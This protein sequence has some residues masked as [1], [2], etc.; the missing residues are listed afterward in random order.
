MNKILRAKI[1]FYKIIKSSLNYQPT[2]D[3]SN[4]ILYL[5]YEYELPHDFIKSRLQF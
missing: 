3:R 2:E 5:N 4:S 1:K